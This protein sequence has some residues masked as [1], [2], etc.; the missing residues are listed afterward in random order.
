MR[1]LSREPGGIERR[2]VGRLLCRTVGRNNLPALAADARRVRHVGP[3]QLLEQLARAPL[4]TMLRESRDATRSTIAAGSDGLLDAVLADAGVGLRNLRSRLGLGSNRANGV[5]GDA[6]LLRNRPIALRRV[7]L[8]FGDDQL[9]PLIARQVAT[10]GVP[11]RTYSSTLGSTLRAGF[12]RIASKCLFL[13]ASPGG[14]EPP[15]LP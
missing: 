10:R 1:G 7:A 13:L 4:G 12:S 9:A 11:A 3:C 8:E 2:S 5:R 6:R 14:F 15:Y